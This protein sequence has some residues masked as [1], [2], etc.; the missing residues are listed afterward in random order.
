MGTLKSVVHLSLDGFVARPGGDLSAFPSGAENLA[1]VNELTDTADVGLFGRNSFELLDTHWPGAKDLPGATQEEISYSNWYNRVRKVVVTDSGSPEGT[2]TFPRDCAAHVRQLKATT[3]GDILLFGSPTVTRY[4]LSKSLIDE[5]WIFIN[6]V[7][8][9]E[10]LP[11]FPASSETTRL[12][13]T[14]LKKFPNG[15][16]VMNYRLLPVVA[17]ETLRAEVTVRQPIDVAWLAW[18]SPEAIREW[19]IPFDHWHTPRAE[20][21]LRPGG[22]FFYRMETKDGREGFD[23]RGRYDRIEFQELITLTLDD[24]RKSFIRFASDGKRTIVTEQFE[25]EADSPPE[26]QKEFCQKV[27]ERFKAY[28]EG[29]GI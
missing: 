19:N 2:E 28:V 10:G 24:G 29:K 17:K 3:A 25:P 5:L 15:E 16:I 6:P 4:L 22:A 7:L 23:Y 8:F 13:L 14:T 11:L 27:L 9:G 20:N 21:D 1:F 26:L 12:A 18:T